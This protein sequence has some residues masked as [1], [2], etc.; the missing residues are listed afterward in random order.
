MIVNMFSTDF[1]IGLGFGFIF[2]LIL[3]TVLWY[4]Y[5]RKSIIYLFKSA[6]Q[7][8]EKLY[9]LLEDGVEE[10]YYT[11]EEIIIGGKK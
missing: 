1:L 6:K 2:G 9:K 5:W 8:E 7:N 10:G 3:A 11:K 4:N